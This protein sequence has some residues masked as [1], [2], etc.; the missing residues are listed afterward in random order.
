MFSVNYQTH[1]KSADEPFGCGT[2]QDC[3][4]DIQFLR[5]GLNTQESV[6]YGAAGMI[7]AIPIAKMAWGDGRR[8]QHLV[9]QAHILYQ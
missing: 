8:L 1:G 7:L 3:V 4:D 9:R 6:I 5:L 2:H